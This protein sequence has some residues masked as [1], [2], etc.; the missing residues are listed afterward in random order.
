MSKTVSPRRLTASCLAAL[1]FLALP[2]ALSAEVR[3]R[4]KDLIVEQASDL[5]EQARLPAE[6]CFLHSDAA[7]A[8][9]LYVEQQHGT[10]LAVFDVTNPAHIKLAASSTLDAP[11]PFDFVRPLSG[12][13]EL[14]RFRDGRGM[15]MLDLRKAKAP[16]LRKIGNLADAGESLGASAVL[17]A[18]EPPSTPTLV[19]ARDYQVVDTSAGSE[20]AVLAT[21]HQVTA[22][23]FNSDTGTTFLLG[24]EGLSVIRRPSVEIDHRQRLSE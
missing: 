5:P 15:A 24:S 4:A 22:K 16:T 1:L 10:H 19:A 8:T 6:S 9:Y 21:V 14:I 23:V 2:D 18:S 13:A 20:G 11:A 12:Q 17:V 3:S 7:G